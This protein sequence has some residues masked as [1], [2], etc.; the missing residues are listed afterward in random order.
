MS[1]VNIS[2]W[3]KSKAQPFC[4][5]W[6][7]KFSLGGYNP[8][9]LGDRSPPVGSMGKPKQFADTVYRFWM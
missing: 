2:L 5:W 6:P 4:Q 7:Q 9:S 1:A 3:Y 8:G